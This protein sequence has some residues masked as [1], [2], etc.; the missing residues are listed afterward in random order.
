MKWWHR[1]T[2]AMARSKAR[3]YTCCALILLCLV[4]IIVCIAVL[5]R[6][7]CPTGTFWKAAVAADSGRCSEI[8]R[9]VTFETF[10][11][12]CSLYYVPT[13]AKYAGFLT[14]VWQTLKHFGDLNPDNHHYGSGGLWCFS[15]YEAAPHPSN[16]FMSSMSTLQ[17][18]IA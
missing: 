9:W 18:A 5:A 15:I 3:V 8:G 17:Y 11:P 16:E 1:E 12:N 13:K 14:K 10:Q 7:K 6:R 2:T 4:A